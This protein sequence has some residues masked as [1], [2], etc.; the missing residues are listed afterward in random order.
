MRPFNSR[1]LLTTVLCAALLGAGTVSAALP[2]TSEPVGNQ[3]PIAENLSL[4]TYKNVAITGYLQAVDAE[5]DVLTFQLTSTPARGSVALAEDGTSRFVYTPYNNKTGKDSFTFVAVDRVGN[6]SNPAKVT[7]HIEKA[8]T[9][10]TYSDMEGNPAHKAAIRLAEQGI[11]V[12]AHVGEQ[13][14]FSPDTPVSRSQFLAMAMAVADLDPLEQVSVTGFADDNA[15]PTWAKGYVSSALRAGVIHGARD[16]DGRIVFLP[17]APVTRAQ[18]TV[19]LND[20]LEVSDVAVQSWSA[21]GIDTQ[22][23][24]HWA[25]QAA[26]NLT[27]AGVLPSSGALTQDFDSVLTRAEVA[28]LLDSSLDLLENRNSR[29]FGW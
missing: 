23:S 2:D 19:M 17:D 3:A 16:V 7:V 18:A 26:A 9:S 27:T 13:Y 24:S 20:L 8:N 28:E 6:I 15:I 21:S 1:I 5:G 25:M 29:W 10:I 11:F 4:T 14:F 22:D 12:G